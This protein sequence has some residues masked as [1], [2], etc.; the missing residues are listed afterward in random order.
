MQKVQVVVPKRRINQDEAMVKGLKFDNFV[1]V[2]C[3]SFILKMFHKCKRRVVEQ[4]WQQGRV[5]IGT[6]LLHNNKFPV[7]GGNL[8]LPCRGWRP[9]CIESN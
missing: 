1:F 9:R 5:K 8:S 2:T 3:V 4:V 7:P 6:S